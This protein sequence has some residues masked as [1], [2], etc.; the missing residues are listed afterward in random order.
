MGEKFPRTKSSCRPIILPKATAKGGCGKKEVRDALDAIA[1]FQQL[2]K[3]NVD[4][5]V[6]T[7]LL[8]HR[9]IGKIFVYK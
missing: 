6:P 3:D 2:N 7:K 9:G 4:S 5:A 8:C 1:G